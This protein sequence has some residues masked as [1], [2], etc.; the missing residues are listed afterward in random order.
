MGVVSSKKKGCPC[1]KKNGQNPVIYFFFYVA[2]QLRLRV[3]GRLRQ[4]CR[5]NHVDSIRFMSD[6]GSLRCSF[7]FLGVSQEF[8]DVS[9]VVLKKKKKYTYTPKKL[10]NKILSYN[11]VL[12]GWLALLLTPIHTTERERERE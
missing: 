12:S 3:N 4:A 1:S 7:Q 11:L 9:Q 10:L 8:L 2:N 5:I 6:S